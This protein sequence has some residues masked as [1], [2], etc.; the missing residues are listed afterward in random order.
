MKINSSKK[1]KSSKSKTNENEEFSEETSDSEEKSQSSE[2]SSTVDSDC[3]DKETLSK[4]KLDTC[5]QSTKDEK[6]Q[7][8]DKYANKISPGKS[9]DSGCESDA[10]E[11]KEKL[12]KNES[13][14]VDKNEKDKEN[15]S[16]D[17]ANKKPDDHMKTDTEEDSSNCNSSEEKSSCEKDTRDIEDSGG[18]EF[19]KAPPT[20]TITHHDDVLDV[21]DSDDYLLYLE[22]ILINIHSE[23]YRLFDLEK[24]QKDNSILPDI[25]TLVPEMKSKVLE[26]VN[27]LFSGVIPQHH[28][29]YNSKAY[30]IAKSLGANVSDK[31]VIKGKGSK[32]DKEYTTHLIAAN[33]HTEKVHQARKSK[34][35]KVCF[36]FYFN[37]FIN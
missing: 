16:E 35:I 5:D 32:N 37:L 22:E 33:L 4:E 27:I 20:P 19:L 11:E 18:E 34:Y 23:F 30:L 28:E 8:A 25:K 12:V 10:K 17:E 2:K 9:E 6:E 31:L 3:E 24:F 13:K 29:L 1:S 15:K 14:T 7:L 26:G 36:L 21:P